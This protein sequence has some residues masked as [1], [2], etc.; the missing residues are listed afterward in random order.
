MPDTM[1]EVTSRRRPGLIVTGALVAVGGIVAALGAV[2]GLR[3]A[4]RRR[5]RDVAPAPVGCDTTLEFDD[6]GTYYI[7][8][9]TKGEV[10]D[11]DGDCEND[12]RSYD[13]ED[14]DSRS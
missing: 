8:A 7:F 9:E 14:T 13:G 4:V 1:T 6:G 10:G 5:H 11:V 3:V 2:A 12:D